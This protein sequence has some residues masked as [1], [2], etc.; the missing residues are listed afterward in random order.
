MPDGKIE[1]NGN[2]GGAR[3]F[4]PGSEG[5]GGGRQRDHN[6]EAEG[7]QDAHLVVNPGSSNS[8]FNDVQ[9]FHER[10]TTVSPLRRRK[11]IP[12]IA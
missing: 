12:Q 3:F 7:A 11:T 8:G 1:S 4:I 6:F 5:S 2:D 10:Q 9:N